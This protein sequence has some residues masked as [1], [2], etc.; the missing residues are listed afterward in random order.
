MIAGL[1]Y[2][3]PGSP[4]WSA[5]SIA[6][7]RRNAS[8]R[9][10]AI[11]S[12]SLFAVSFL[13]YVGGFLVGLFLPP[14]MFIGSIVS[15]VAGLAHLIVFLFFLRSLA[16]AVR[17]GDLTVSVRNF[18]IAIGV[19]IVGYP[20]VATIVIV[21]STLLGAAS[22]LSGVGRSPEAMLFALGVPFLIVVALGATL[23]LGLF[24]WYVRILISLRD[25]LDRMMDEPHA[26]AP[27]W[28]PLFQGA[29]VLFVIDFIGLII[30][31][32]ALKPPDMARANL[33][34]AAP[35]APAPVFPQPQP[36]F[37]QPQPVYPQPQ[38]V[39]PQPQPQPQALPPLA[40]PRR[41]EPGVHVHEQTINRAGVSMKVWV[42]LPETPA[43]PKLPCV[44]V[45]PAG[46]PL[47]TGMALADGYRT[48]PLPYVK[49]GFAVVAFP[50][51]AMCRT[52][53]RDRRQDRGRSEGISQRR[54][55]RGESPRRHGLRHREAPAIDA[56]RFYTA[57]HSSAGTLSLLA[58]SGA[59]IKLHRHA[60]CTDGPA[61]APAMPALSQ[62]MPWF[63]DSPAT[64]P[65][66]HAAEIKCPVFLSRYRRHQ[67]ADRNHGV[68]RGVEEDQHASASCRRARQPLRFM[69]QEG[70]PEGSSGCRACR[71]CRGTAPADPMPADPMPDT[72]LTKANLAKI[73][74]GSTPPPPSPFWATRPA[75]AIPCIGRNGA[76]A[77]L[78][79][80]NVVVIITLVNDRAAANGIGLK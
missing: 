23:C 41:L 16:L 44:F 5:R 60:P 37:P 51:T 24:I 68:R 58:A 6:A 48:E 74:A 59:A 9:I 52:W 25:E 10:L 21:L 70:I 66:S 76:N 53:A 32:Y 49:A 42:Y 30:A 4:T 69:I 13:S 27:V 77:H 57:G 73:Q 43:A 22:Q 18:M 50:W 17:A 20:I 61:L 26:R 80:G 14:L 56:E 63:K 39:F 2:F 71:L 79:E 33:P 3:A 29:A 35:V 36:V 78:R 15:M 1:F 12:V 19:S 46:S 62:S 65:L 72:K 28:L 7:S 67:R 45:A 47:F 40:P 11:I 38:P 31:G 34:G 55:G 54:R 64:P 8:A 75:P